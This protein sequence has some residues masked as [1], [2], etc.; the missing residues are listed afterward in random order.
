MSAA[1][2]GN[3]ADGHEVR[4]YDCDHFSRPRTVVDPNRGRVKGDSRGASKEILGHHLAVLPGLWD[5][6]PQREDSVS[7][8]L[9]LGA[10]QR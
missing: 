10:N 6:R 9:T 8:L 4:P 2:R 1:A 3:G 7:Q 5:G